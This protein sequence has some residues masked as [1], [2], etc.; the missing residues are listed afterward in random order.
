[1]NIPIVFE[2]NWLVV[3]DKPSGL[4]VIP[5]PKKESRT[6][7][8]I[9]NDDLAER[10]I[11]YRL[12]PCHRLDRGTSGLMIYAKGK[13]IQD[14][15][16]EEFKQRR[17]KK[18]Y[19]AFVQGSFSKNAGQIT[20]PIEGKP[21][22]TQYK[23][24]EKRKGFVI[25]EVNPLTGRTN[26]IRIHFADAGH[27]ILG[28]D[29]FVFRRDMALRAKRLCLHARKIEFLHPVSKKSIILDTDLP[30]EMKAFL[31]THD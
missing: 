31:D 9:L 6:L 10:K 4:L 19:L 28:E 22:T 11:A 21:A 5:T 1:M 24:I 13:S 23:V 29:R 3:V 26:Q 17:V 16:M 8:S 18:T 15:M 25:V 14:K 27:P 12:H 20:V 30:K 7:T 2:D